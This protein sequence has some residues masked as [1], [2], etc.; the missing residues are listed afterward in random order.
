MSRTILI[1]C[2][3]RRP[4]DGVVVPVRLVFKSIERANFLGVQWHPAVVSVPAF[5][6]SLGFDGRSFGAAPSP[7]IGELVFALTQATRFAA[8]LVWSNAAIVMRHAVWPASGRD[9]AD[10]DFETIWTGQAEDIATGD[11]QARVRLLDNGQALRVPAA[12]AKFGSTGD[13]LLDSAD[14]LKDRGAETRVPRAWGRLL[15]IPALLVDRPNNIWLFAGNAATSVQGF[16]DGGAAFTLGTARASLAALQANVPAA[17]AVD[18]CL[19]AGGKFLARPW[20]TPVYPFTAAATFGSATAANIASAIVT[21]RTSITFTAGT[22]AAF[23][24]LQGA[25]CGLY[26]DDDTSV[27]SALD[28][29]FSGLGAWWRLSSAG[30]IT[31]GRWAWGSPALTIPAHRRHTPQRLRVLAPTRRRSLGYARN[32]RVHSESEIA[33][34]LLADDL[35]YVDGTSIEA[36][37]PATAG[38]TRNVVT[39]SMAEPS[40][41]VNND[42]WVDL[43]G[44]YAV[45]K[46]RVGGA[47]VTGANALSAYNALSGTPVSLADINTTESSKLAGIAANATRDRVGNLLDAAAAANEAAGWNTSGGAATAANSTGGGWGAFV[48]PRFLGIDLSVAFEA[49]NQVLMPVG[50]TGRQYAAIRYANGSPG[51]AALAGLLYFYDAAGTLL[52]PQPAFSLPRTASGVYST[53]VISGAVPAGAVSWRIYFG[54]AA[55]IETANWRIDNIVALHNEPGADV[56]A[57]AVP[58]LSVPPLVT[59]NFDFTGT[60]SPGALPA[61]LRAVRKRGDVDVS[62]STS[63]SLTGSGFTGSIASD[64]AITI[65]AVTA[66]TIMTV[67]STRDGVTLSQDVGINRVVAPPPA[68]GGTGGTT[69]NDSSID[70]IASNSYGAAI[71]GPMTVKTG[72]VGR[73]DL[74]APLTITRGA[75][76]P[77][78]TF[79][80]RLKWQ[81]RIVG[82]TYADAAS[83]VSEDTPLVVTVESGV[84]FVEDGAVTCNAAVTGLSAN[85]DYEVQL[86]GRTNSGTTSRGMIGT[87]SAVGS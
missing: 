34:I 82:G 47:W 9:A 86:L 65:T 26:L 21:G 53:V 36:L 87:A 15:S 3:P 12:A 5:E 6:S 67:V 85:T 27:A 31:L 49:F 13:A 30:T 64:G 17:G 8:S 66:S 62:T 68:L 57:T 14:A 55:P 76:A 4:S 72:S 75:T 29:L 25:E 42:I 71:A 19:D 50:G 46:L 37:K 7:Q 11:G 61:T 40:S 45:F 60:A 35:T 18:Y 38:A 22:V 69:A 23:N 83:E 54:S 2:S 41:P 20:S 32:D 24:A 51:S 48:N 79:G 77:T 56:T 80:V 63:W 16:F 28:R 43:T 44:I 33:R 73:I 1:E 10:S 84:Y 70:S 58:S 52:S 39:Y 81:W 74:Y 78:G 59:V